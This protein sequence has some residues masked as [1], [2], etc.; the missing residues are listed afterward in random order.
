MKFIHLA[1][2]HIGKRVNAF[3]MLED[4]RYI[5]KQILTILREERPDGGVILA[6]DIYDKAIPSAEA[7]EL[8]D[9]FLTQLAALRLRVFIIAG[10]HDSPERIAFGNRLM[11]RSGIYLSPVYDGHV[12]RITCPDSAASVTLSAANAVDLNAGTHSVES[13]ST[14]AAASTCPPVDVYLLP[15]LKPA[16]VRRFYPEE[17]I[18]SYTDAMRVAIAYMDIDPTHRNL[19]VTHQ[20]VTGASRS[21]SEDISVGGSDNVDAS[22]FAPF[23]YVALGHLHG[24]QQVRFQPT[25]EEDA[26]D[27]DATPATSSTDRSESPAS[28]VENTTV[29][30]IIR[31]AGTPLKYSFSEARHHKSVTVVEIG[32]KKADGVVDVCISTR[33]LR[34]LHDMREIRGSYE[35]LTLRA[36]YEGTATDDYIHATLTDEI[37]IPDAAR[38]L[39]VIYPNLM[40]LDYDNARTRGQGSERLEL[41]QL[42]EKSPL[43]LFSELFEKQNHKEMT[44]EQ[45]RYVQA[46]MEKIWEA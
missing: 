41:E 44:E 26:S 34:P 10:N 46:Q 19:L 2:L 17:T 21:D 23:D 30:P 45:A 1:D 4:Q 20:F 35:E 29:G 12:K 6:G 7:V 25:P 14:S 28:T 5:L 33:E 27:Q 43:D 18:E 37:E 9:E 11:D 32:E 24:P 42:E 40:K 31:Y 3:P 16:N 38:H 39:Q 15:F 36:N 22:V 13:A 8:F